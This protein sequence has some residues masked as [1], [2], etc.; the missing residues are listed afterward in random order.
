MILYTKNNDKI[1]CTKTKA[2]RICGEYVYLWDNFTRKI[3]EIETKFCFTLKNN[4]SY[5]YF[6]Y[7]NNW[8]KTPM[9]TEEGLDLWNYFE[10]ERENLYLERK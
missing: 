10:L 6:L 2:P 5:F 4:R 1:R 8:Y 3:N 9:I 7:Q